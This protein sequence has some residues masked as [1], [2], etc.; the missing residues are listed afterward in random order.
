[1]GMGSF[2]VQLFANLTMIRKVNE[3]FATRG[4]QKDAAYLG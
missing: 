1:M 3:L 2:L 4:L